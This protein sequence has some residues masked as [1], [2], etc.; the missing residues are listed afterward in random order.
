MF[1]YLRLGDSFTTDKGVDVHL[2][3]S[4]ESTLGTVPLHL[5]HVDDLLLDRWVVAVPMIR[6][7]ASV[8]KHN[9]IRRWAMRAQTYTA[10]CRLG[11]LSII[12][13]ST[14]DACDG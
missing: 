5:W 1:T 3:L 7:V 4:L 6:C 14:L 10:D 11:V 2:L 12:C 13:S 9:H 8:A